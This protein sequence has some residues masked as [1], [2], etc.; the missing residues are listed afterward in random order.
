[1]GG[2]QFSTLYLA[3]HLPNERWLPIVGSPAE[4]KLTAACQ[5]AGLVTAIIPYPE[6]KPTSLRISRDDRRIPDPFAWMLNTRSIEVARRQALTLIR[7]FRPDLVI[8]KG[9]FSHIYGGLAS[10]QADVPC[11]WHMQDFIS[12]RHFGIYRRTLAPFA[13]WLPAMI[14]TDGSPIAEQLP[15][16]VQDK[17][18][19]VL[20]GVDTDMFQPGGEGSTLRFEFNI[21]SD[22]LIIGHAARFTPW[23]GQLYLLDAYASLTPQFPNSRLMLVGAPVFDNDNYF[24]QLRKRTIELGIE[25]HVIYTGFRDDL[26]QALAAMDIFAYPSIEKDTSPLALLSAMASGLPVVAFDIPGVREVVD[27]AGLLVPN[28]DVDAL[29]RGMARLLSQADLRQVI[30]RKSRQRALQAFSLERHVK[31]MGTLFEQCLSQRKGS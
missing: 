4:G 26:P 18:R 28:R 15:A 20:N 14:I 1:M 27:K 9:L 2:V 30:S 21:P 22:A 23:K 31:M 6:P 10:R 5:D 12:E 25:S 13:H 11:I 17:T 29:S 8:T 19:V 7:N 3:S 24:N 16:S